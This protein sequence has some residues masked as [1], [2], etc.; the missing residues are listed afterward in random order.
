MR[1][2]IST[3]SAV[4]FL[5]FLALAAARLADAG[6]V[7]YSYDASN[8][9]TGVQYSSGERIVYTYDAVGNRLSRTATIQTA[10]LTVTR[11]GAGTG[12]VQST[13]AGIDC[14]FTC[15]ASYSIGTRVTLRAVPAPGS[16]F[17]SWSGDCSGM[18]ACEVGLDVARSVT[19]AFELQTYSV[20]VQRGGAGSGSVVSDLPGIACGEDCTES[21]PFGTAVTLRASPAVGSVFAGWG[22]PCS[23]TG[24][25]VVAVSEAAVVGASFDVQ[26]FDLFVSRAGAGSGSVASD[27][28]GIACGTDCVEGYPYGTVVAL[29][30]AP[31]PESIFVG[32]SGD[33]SGTGSCVLTMDAGKS[34]VA[35]FAPSQRDSDGDG[36]PDDRDLCPFTPVGATDVD[37]NGCS[38]C[39]DLNHPPV[40]AVTGPRHVPI[41][42]T[43]AL[44]GSLSTDPDARA[45]RAKGSLLAFNWVVVAR[46]TDSAASLS[47]STGVRVTIKPDVVGT[48][49][50]QLV[51]Q[52]GCVATPPVL[53]TL[54]AADPAAG[55]V[56]PNAN[57]GPPQVVRIG[58]TVT[59]D[60]QGSSDPDHGPQPL[61]F[62]WS[63]VAG[64]VTL[65]LTPSA[66]AATFVP[67]VAGQYVF[68]LTVSDGQA[69]DQAHVTVGVVTGNLPPTV[70][71]GPDVITNLG[72]WVVLTGSASDPDGGP[73]AL[74][75]TW[76]LLSKPA[77][78]ARTSANIA[79]AHKRTVRFAPDAPGQ[80]L[81]ELHVSDGDLTAADSVLVTVFRRGDVNR[82][83]HIDIDDVN[84]IDAALNTR[85]SGPD[86]P[87]DLDNDGTIDDLDSRIAARLCDKPRCA[88]QAPPVVTQHPWPM[89]GHDPRHT[90]RSEYAGPQSI[91]VRWAYDLSL[92]VSR[93][94]GGASVQ[95][96]IGNGNAV[97]FGTGEVECGS[98]TQWG[99]LYGFNPD[100]T[101]ASG[102]FDL[103]SP[104]FSAPAIGPDGTIY[105]PTIDKGVYALNPDGTEK[106]RFYEEGMGNVTG[107]S[108]AGDGTI[109]FAGYQKLYSLNSDGSTNWTYC[110][111]RRGGSASAG[112]AIA[113]TGDIHVV[114]TGFITGTDGETG[115]LHSYRRD[116][117]LKW[118]VPLEFGFV[119]LT[120]PSVAHDGT[121]YVAQGSYSGVG[122]RLHAFDQ[123]GQEI[124]QTPI[125]SRGYP[126]G[127][128]VIDTHGNVIV[129]ANWTELCGEILW[130]FASG[131][132]AFAPNG[133]PLWQI[134]PHGGQVSNNTRFTQPVLD[135]EGTVFIAEDISSGGGWL[136]GRLYSIGEEGSVR[137]TIQIPGMVFSSPVIGTD[138]YLY[139]VLGEHEGSGLYRIKGYAFGP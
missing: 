91:T 84:L 132:Y 47:S 5:L 98:N 81:F 119:R 128:P 14:G 24:N 19:A 114:W 85:T 115:A 40:A 23:G 4:S 66:A 3:L 112:P 131:L 62:E 7:I 55:N 133:D 20:A 67:T 110:C 52:D 111:G 136:T 117:T 107:I 78:S 113:A 36:V 8:R 21:Y 134:G 75:L 63:Q 48:Y 83:G 41:G 39:S 27:R 61:T 105:V 94:C 87:R 59:L 96:V 123:D 18:G 129:A 6:T 42:E 90:G 76:V 106:W 29:A 60:G 10:A 73:G 53:F 15:E 38:L 31:L 135:A 58:T 50:A 45:A 26:S 124:W 1:L 33:C 100:G 92:N 57:A 25:C 130:C 30:A 121:V 116:G 126:Q 120:A 13:P 88:P 86:D 127:S 97:Y 99:K 139:A 65:D 109:Y 82:D 51:V 80:Y 93:D 56:P 101:L 68:E 72:K 104:V 118:S 70:S 46:P 103:G 34:V 125:A 49:A 71:A 138:G 16:T 89:F 122:W 95:S 17:T 28:P 44:D 69:S 11:V 12:T 43:A 137:E 22:G 74:G 108:V 102:S 9:L 64:P 37:A 35:T 54:E 77:A 2:S 79:G 32:W